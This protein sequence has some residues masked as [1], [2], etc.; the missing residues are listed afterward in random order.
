MKISVDISMYPLTESFK[1]PILAFIHSLQSN[2]EITVI[3][4]N[5]STQIFGEFDVLMPLLNSNMKTAMET[6]KSVVMILKV[7]NADLK[8]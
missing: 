5:M 2:P 3:R 4:N 1:P 6:D 7:V 8:D